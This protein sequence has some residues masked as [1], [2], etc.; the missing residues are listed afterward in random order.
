MA[1]LICRSTISEHEKVN[2]FFA[3]WGARK[4]KLIIFAV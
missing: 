1:S 4:D 2:K 3:N